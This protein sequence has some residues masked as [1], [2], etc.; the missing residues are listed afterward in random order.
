MGPSAEHAART[1]AGERTG[2]ATLAQLRAFQVAVGLD[3]RATPQDAVANHA[4]RS[5]VHVVLDHHAAFQHHV[6][7]DQHVAADRDFATDIQAL[8]IEQGHALAHQL[9]RAQALVVTLQLG[10]LHAVINALHFH[11]VQRLGAG[12]HQ[13]VADRHGDHVGQVVLALGV[14]VGQAAEPVGRRLPGTARMPVLISPIWRCAGVASLCSTMA[15]TAPWS[16]R[17]MRP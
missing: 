10:L 16:S 13:A 9:L 6:D 4:V 15:C 8:R 3:H 1:Q 2:I 17:T 14:V 5:D 12:Y 11:R 7:V